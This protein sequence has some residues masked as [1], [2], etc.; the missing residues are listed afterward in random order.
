MLQPCFP[1]LLSVRSELIY[2]WFGLQIR[3]RR[4]VRQ[5]LVPLRSRAELASV[6]VTAVP[7]LSSP[8][9]FWGNNFK[10]EGWLVGRCGG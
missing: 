4:C 3:L 5:I 2:A 10:A 7:R 9:G 6:P 1:P 8:Q